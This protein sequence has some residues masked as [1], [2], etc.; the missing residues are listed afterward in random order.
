MIGILPDVAEW[1]SSP[2]S[3]LLKLIS[4]SSFFFLC[5]FISLAFMMHSPLLSFFHTLNRRRG[6]GQVGRWK[7]RTRSIWHWIHHTCCAVPHHWR[8]QWTF[9][10][11]HI[12]SIDRS[13]SCMDQSS[14]PIH[15]PTYLFHCTYSHAY[16]ISNS[17]P[18]SSLLFPAL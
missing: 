7:V 3:S 6:T 14:L 11:L 9:L 4:S 18:Y 13:P 10:S 1:N 15:Y 5:S 2:Y 16:F 17:R 12:P 8:H